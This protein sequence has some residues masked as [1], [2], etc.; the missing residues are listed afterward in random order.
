MIR[1]THLAA[2]FGLEAGLTASGAALAQTQTASTPPPPQPA[3][4]TSPWAQPDPPITKPSD[5]DAGQPTYAVDPPPEGSS[6]VYLPAAVLGYA[7]SAAGCVVVG[8]NDGPQGSGAAV[9]ATPGPPPPAPVTP[10]PANPG[11]PAP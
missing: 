5:R 8:C 1:A 6:G 7:K 11:S 3:S 2:A 9:P 10:T 4:S